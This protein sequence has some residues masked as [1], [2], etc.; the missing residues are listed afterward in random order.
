[1]DLGAFTIFADFQCAVPA[2]YVGTSRGVYHSV[3]LGRHWEKFGEFLPNAEV[4]DL[5]YLPAQNILAAATFGRSAWEILTE[6]SQISGRVF[7]DDE[8]N[9][10]Q[11]ASDK[12]V[13][14][15]LVF[16]DSD[17]DGKFDSTER[18]TFTDAQGHYAFDNVAP[19]TY[20]ILQVPPPSYSQSTPVLSNITVN[21]SSLT[22]E[23]MGDT[24]VIPIHPFPGPI[25]GRA[26]YQ[27][28]L[29]LSNA[30]M[31]GSQ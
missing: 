21:G 28:A 9:G 27:M 1:T 19:G 30:G 10:I 20:S 25:N 16:L 14:N 18:S 5:Q 8:R 13:P 17:G 4:R 7:V 15:A 6:P 2:L 24:R 3:D 29:L 22:Q 23:D 26:L 12:G 11:D 31:P